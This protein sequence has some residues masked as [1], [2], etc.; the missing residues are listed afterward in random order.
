[1]LLRLLTALTALLALCVGCD[2]TNMP[3]HM[4][5]P[6]NLAFNPFGIPLVVLGVAGVALVPAGGW[7]VIW[8][9]AAILALAT[10][11][12][13][14]WEGIPIEDG[15][16]QVMRAGVPDPDRWPAPAYFHALALAPVGT[17]V[18]ALLPGP[19]RV[20]SL[21]LATVVAVFGSGFGLQAFADTLARYDTGAGLVFATVTALG[22]LA[23]ITA[24]GGRPA[25]RAI[26][27]QAVVLAALCLV[28]WIEY[29][30]PR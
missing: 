27:G 15:A 3:L 5:G 29:T 7:T 26:A 18:A 13:N 6:M 23:L 21:L 14:F 2:L 11:G 12:V 25:G 1:M 8:P 17:A 30:R 24:W 4:D 9:L 22:L 16:F 28:L 10:A 20:A 19:R